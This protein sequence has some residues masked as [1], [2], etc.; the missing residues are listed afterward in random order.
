M[1]S[2]SKYN[3]GFK[4]LLCAIDLFSKYAWV[5][6]IK[7]KKGTSIVNAFKKIISERQRKPN[8]IWVDQGSEFYNQSFKDFLKIN[9]IEMYS[10]YNEGKSVVAERFIRTLKNK[11]FKHMTIISKNVYIDVLND[12]VNKCNNTIHRTIKMRPLMLQIILLLNT[13][14]I[15]IKKILNLKLV[16]V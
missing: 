1:Q 16:I 2:L 10:T 3:K 6:P 7:N 15:Q 5:I 8:K 4:Y 9:N 12:I 13:I 11:I 14:K